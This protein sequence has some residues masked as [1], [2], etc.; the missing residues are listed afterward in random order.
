MH[1]APNDPSKAN[2]RRHSRSRCSR[3]GHGMVVVTTAGKPNADWKRPS[4]TRQRVV[5][6][7]VGGSQPGRP[8]RQN[9]NEER[10]SLQHAAVTGRTSSVLPDLFVAFVPVP[11]GSHASRCRLM[12]GRGKAVVEALADSSFRSLSRVQDPLEPLLL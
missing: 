3:Q 9:C 7:L 10:P 1:H 5:P 12:G 4:G 11:G 8:Y 6:N 2:N